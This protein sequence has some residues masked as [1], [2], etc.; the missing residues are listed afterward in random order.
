MYGL[1]N[2][3][4]NI[5]MSSIAIRRHHPS[6]MTK[7]HLALLIVI[8]SSLVLWTITSNISRHVSNSDKC[9]V[10]FGTYRGSIYNKPEAT[11]DNTCLVESPW[12]RL[13]Q[14]TV[15]ISSNNGENSKEKDIIDDWIFIDYHDRINVLVEAPSSTNT[16]P[17]QQQSSSQEKHEE[18]KF[19]LLTQTKYALN[20]DSYAIVGGIIE[21]NEESLLAA[22]REVNEELGVTCTNWKGLGK[23]RK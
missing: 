1:P 4:D 14:H 8:V 5:T 18:R 21:P 7:Y 16:T 6:C 11:I 10:S 2:D 23:F 9:L 13:A 22:K 15:Q 20:E 3:H 19:I 12:I 17:K